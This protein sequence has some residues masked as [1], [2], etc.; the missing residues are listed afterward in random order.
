MGG[1]VA[2]KS[3]FFEVTPESFK[4]VR[5]FDKGDPYDPPKGP[6]GQE[7]LPLTA[8]KAALEQIA[9]IIEEA[10]QLPE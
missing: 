9:A 7:M 2:G 5:V 3:K 1:Q 4:L 10:R 8:V 6:D